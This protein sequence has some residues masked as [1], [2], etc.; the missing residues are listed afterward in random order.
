MS[1]KSPKYLS[2]RQVA[3][4]LGVTEVTV[5]R[6]RVEKKGP[7][8]TKLGIGSHCRYEQSELK[9]WLEGNIETETDKQKKG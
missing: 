7:K 8:F 2:T 4:I 5:R 9:K 1:H 3:D 6:W